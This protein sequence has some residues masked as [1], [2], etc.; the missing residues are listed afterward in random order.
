MS[1]DPA[2]DPDRFVPSG[3]EVGP[4]DPAADPDRYDAR[5]PGGRGQTLDDL[6]GEAED[7]RDNL[8]WLFGLIGVLAFL[9]L[10]SLLLSH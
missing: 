5:K 8:Q 6:M 9:V 1:L 2:Q 3:E 7:K 10:V 4:L